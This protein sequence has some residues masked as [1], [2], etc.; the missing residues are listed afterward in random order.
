VC[1][2]LIATTA[3]KAAPGYWL[4]IAAVCGLIA[5]LL[6]YRRRQG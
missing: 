1:T 6:L 5:T 4:S 2:W 3:D